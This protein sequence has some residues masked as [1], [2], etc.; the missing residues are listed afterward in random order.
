MNKVY[1]LL[2]ACLCYNLLYSQCGEPLP[3]KME[4]GANVNGLADW[5]HDR[6]FNDLIKTSRGFSSDTLAPYAADNIP[7][8]TFGWPLQD[9]GFVVLSEMDSTEGGTYKMRFNGKATIHNLVNNYQVANQLYDSA[10]N[11]TTADLVFPIIIPQ[12][13]PFIISFTNTW[14]N[15]STKGLKNIQIMKPGLGFNAQTFDST[16][17]DHLHRFST[18]RFMD[19]QNTNG[20][21]DSLW[22]ERTLLQSAV[23]ANP[24][25]ASLEYC[26]QLA[27]LLHK[28]MWLCVPVKADSNYIVNMAQLLHDSLDPT[29]HVYVEHSN[30]IWNYAFPQATYNQNMAVA[31]AAQP[32]SPLSYDNTTDAGTLAIR[33]HGLRCKTISDL[34]RTVYGAAEVN[35]RFRVVYGVQYVY[36]DFTRRGIDFINDYYGD[37]SQYIYA[38]AA[39]PYFSSSYAESNTS[40]TSQDILN[41]LQLYTDSTIYP[42]YYSQIEQW[43]ARATFYK[44]KLLAYEGGP[45]TYGSNNIAAKAQA[46]R[47]AQMGSLCSNLLL[48]WYAYGG[49]LFNWFTAGAGNWNTPY[50]TWS[51][52]ERFEY[53][54]KLKAIDS[55]LN[56]TP[57]YPTVGQSV[58]DT[59]DA[60]YVAGYVASNLAATSYSPGWQDVDEWIVRVPK[61][62]AGVFRF[63]IETATYATGLYLE[64]HIDE[65]NMGIYILPTT[66]TSFYNN[67][68][69]TIT[70]TEGLHTVRLNYR[71]GKNFNLRDFIF[72]RQSTCAQII[73]ASEDLNNNTIV[74]YPNPTTGEV[75]IKTDDLNPETICVYDITGERVIEQKYIGKLDIRTLNA[76]V[77]F[78]ELK[79][80][81]IT[82]RGKLV[83]VD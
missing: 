10:T 77:Y 45:D 31:E 74:I 24:N 21:P 14:F 43:A 1:L 34:F 4:L 83:K 63:G 5:D 55:V 60:R 16:F 9:F 22:S 7:K 51:L 75:L 12:G 50:G 13:S 79:E 20:S 35:K 25:G 47:T 40:A 30:E 19:W 67:F 57:Y 17:L 61:D 27:N 46:S 41:A 59:I 78:I 82:R 56:L 26:I 65:R 49:S 28:D 73:T 80:K 33:R 23:Q 62:S 38:I 52:T 69:D 64:S 37:P 18:L 81:N 2:F 53:S 39:A 68:L 66:L 6:P 71:W 48:K 70:L 72:E 29:L 15:D 36:F 11:T 58:N 3:T 44:L 76:G 8:D 54:N 42:Q 32:G